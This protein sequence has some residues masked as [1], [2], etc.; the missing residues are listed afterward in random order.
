MTPAVMVEDGVAAM[1]VALVQATPP[2]PEGEPDALLEAFDVMV[3]MR[4]DILAR[5]AS[6]TSAVAATGMA[7]GGQVL[8]DELRRRDEAWLQALGRAQNVVG[9]RLRAVRRAQQHDR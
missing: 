8:V 7:A 4:A 1:L 2:P 3:A 9:D 6:A 5:M